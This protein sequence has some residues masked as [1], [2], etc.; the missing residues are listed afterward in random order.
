ML[1]GDDALMP[2]ETVPLAHSCTI[3]Q[4][5]QIAARP[6]RNR[7]AQRIGY[8]RI[9]GNQTDLRRAITALLEAGARAADIH[10]DYGPHA[11]MRYRDG[12]HRAL[13]QPEAGDTLIV[14]SLVTFARSQG[15]LNQLLTTLHRR[16]ITLQIHQRRLADIPPAELAD[17][18]AAITDQLLSDIHHERAAARAAQA[19][20]RGSRPWAL[21]PEQTVEVI[22]AF[23][24]GQ[25]RRQIAVDHRIS[26][27]TVF[28]TAS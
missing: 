11:R 16:Q 2:L 4:H 6:C 17:M 28:R 22:E 24:A 12:L 19:G 27:A 23:D 8:A 20:H 21:T 18:T 1:H 10:S 25:P 3:Q 5:E 26:V 15:E 13:L 14:P 9:T 7:A